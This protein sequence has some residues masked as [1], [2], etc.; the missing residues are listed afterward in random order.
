MKQISY[1]HWLIVLL[2]SFTLLIA[3][4]CSNNNPSG[5]DN[6][7]D[8]INQSVQTVSA[9]GVEI[10]NTVSSFQQISGL[11]QGPESIVDLEVPEVENPQKA[12]SFAKSVMKESFDRVRNKANLLSK[13]QGVL[14]D[15]VIWDV[16]IRDEIVGVTIRSSLIYDTDTGE[17]RLFL[18]RYEFRENHPLEYDSTEIAADLNFTLLDDTD[19][20]LLSLNNLKR[21]KPGHLIQQE[22]G[23]FV[24]DPYP[25]GAEPTGG[26]LT[27]DITYSN[28]SFISNTHA[29]LE[30]HEGSGGS[31]LKEVNFSDGTRHSES[32]TFNE[33]GTGTFEENRRDGTRIAGT[34]DSAEEDGQG[35][36]TKI[37]TFPEGHDPVSISESGEFTINPTDSTLNG[38]FEK[39]VRFKNGSVRKESVTVNQ[40][41]VGDVK[42]TTIN[43]ES[44][45]G[46]SGFITIVESPEV[47][48]ISGE[49]TNPDDTF[50]VFSAEFYSDGSAHLKFDLYESEVAYE[51][52][53]DPIASGEFDF[54][55]DGSGHG[56]VTQ[57]NQ[58]YEIT[59]N[60][61][62]TISVKD[63]S[64]NLS[65]LNLWQ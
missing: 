62:G 16:T 6:N 51:N 59:F 29:Q 21:F 12:M 61:D 19:D 55:P 34:F 20:V 22:M 18:V 11:I 37:I 23:S 43:V 65:K 3:I 60:P 33:D 36:F 49:W 64:G 24:P 44:T 46:G 25:A 58:S 10:Y 42:T 4:G 48:Q 30:Y 41:L 32:V 5:P 14:S 38:S 39:E 8:Q 31:Y 15:S 1:T 52:G 56:T 54:F 35:S 17:G 2:L 63:S 47:D 13:P 28:S 57:G 7:D 50:L 26:V 45:H 40:T 9:N 27:S 53:E